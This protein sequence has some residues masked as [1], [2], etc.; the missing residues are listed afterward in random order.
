MTDPIKP[1]FAK[2]PIYEDDGMNPVP[3]EELCPQLRFGR[4]DAERL[5]GL[6]FNTSGSILDKAF[7]PKMVKETK[8]FNHRPIFDGQA[9]YEEVLLLAIL[10]QI[11]MKTKFSP[12][13]L[14]KNMTV[15]NII[16]C[17]HNLFWNNQESVI[18]IASVTGG[19]AEF[20]CI[21][22]ADNI[23]GIDGTI[24]FMMSLRGI[25]EEV[26]ARA[27]PWS[28]EKWFPKLKPPRPRPTAD[29]MVSDAE[30]KMIETIRGINDCIGRYAKV[31]IFKG[32]PLEM[33][34][35]AQAR[36]QPKFSDAISKFTTING[37]GGKTLYETENNIQF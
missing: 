19:A 14:I 6:K 4:N 1:W 3:R 23:C 35:S 26:C 15:W 27:F 28:T 34:W 2:Y 37:V 24:F 13:L 22:E 18:S 20:A 16:A 32:V 8:F 12:A 25:V 7:N 36:E 21:T 17:I 30:R 5:A 31:K 11:H 10:G 29:F 9:T 33:T